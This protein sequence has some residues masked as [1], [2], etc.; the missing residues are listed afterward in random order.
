[1]LIGRL[2]EP[3]RPGDPNGRCTQARYHRH[4]KPDE[5]CRVGWTSF[6][7]NDIDSVE[8]SLRE[9]GSYT[10]RTMLPAR[11]IA[12]RGAGGACATHRLSMKLMKSLSF[13]LCERR[14]GLYARMNGKGVLR[15]KTVSILGIRTGFW[16][17]QYGRLMMRMLY[18]F[19]FTPRGGA[20]V[21]CIANCLGIQQRVSSRT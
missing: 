10:S 7:V 5:L 9:R 20:S 2:H 4:A 6:A 17:G 16:A 8:S 1:M 14:S 19:V 15:I 13:T 3:L 18:V 11:L 21:C 12:W